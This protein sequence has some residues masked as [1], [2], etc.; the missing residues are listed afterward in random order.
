MQLGEKWEKQLELHASYLT[1]DYLREK[2]SLKL[3]A[4]NLLINA[5]FLPNPELIVQVNQLKPGEG[6]KIKSDWIALLINEDLVTKPQLWDKQIKGTQVS[7]PLNHITRL[8]DILNFNAAEIEQDF[9]LITKNRISAKLP[10]TTRLIGAKPCFIEDG[11]IINAAC[12]NTSNGSVYIGKNAELME[13]SVIRGPFAIGE[14][15]QVKMGTKIYGPVSVGPYCK[16]GGEINSSI[17]IGYSSKAHDGF[18]GHSIIGEWCNLGADTNN[19]NL[20]NNY[21]S[22]KLWNYSLENFEST[23][24]T[25]CGLFMG[26]H[27]KTSINAMFNTGTSVGVSSNIFGNGF[28]PTFIPSFTWGGINSEKTYHVEA[29]IKVAEKVMARRNLVMEDQDK[30]ILRHIFVLTNNH[31]KY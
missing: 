16:I 4:T 2:F 20:K 7:M 5:S 26:D 21:A 30:N 22:V 25:F 13:G 12:I 17:I 1:L 6:L 8:W 14:S 23:G 10:K 19:S 31:R 9:Q 11:A 28:P 27:T 29:A 3:G 18:L 15:S 24:L